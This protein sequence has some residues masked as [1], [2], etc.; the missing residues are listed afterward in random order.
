MVFLLGFWDDEVL[1]F[2]L[3]GVFFSVVICIVVEL[4]V[5]VVI[6]VGVLKF[7]GFFVCLI[8]V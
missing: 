2:K 3:L 1:W 8:S 4:L 7:E 5:I 6:K